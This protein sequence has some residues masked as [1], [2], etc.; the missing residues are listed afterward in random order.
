MNTNP[1]YELPDCD[2][3]FATATDVAKS[4]PVYA[5]RGAAALSELAELTTL[6]RRWLQANTFKGGAK[7]HLI[8]PGPEGE[9]AAVLY[10]LGEAAEVYGHRKDGLREAQRNW[11]EGA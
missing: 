10:G 1:P 9:A 8:L 7:S 6:Q 3:A 11:G 4:I 2:K 5:V